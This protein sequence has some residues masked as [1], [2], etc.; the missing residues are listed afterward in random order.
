[1][2]IKTLSLSECLSY[3]PKR[4]RTAHKGDFG[5]VLVVGGDYGFGGAVRLA[6]E[7]ALRSGAGLV[8]IATVPE[9]AYSITGS[10]PEL[11][12][13]GIQTPSDL[14]VL[15][16]RATVIVVGMGLGK[17]TWGKLLL[18]ECLESNLPIVA[19]ADALNLLSEKN[20]TRENWILTPHP[21]EAARLLH[22]T[23]HE[24]QQ[25]RIQ[26]IQSIQQ[27]Y[28]GV[29]VLKGAETLVIDEENQIWQS[30]AGNPGM[31]TG[32]MGDVLSG[33]IGALVAQKL[34]LSQAAKLAV[35]VHATA[36]DKAAR[37]GGERGI[38]ASDLFNYIHELLNAY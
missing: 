1:M 36:G 21:G 27:Q 16:E 28:G 14:T 5:H 4:K 22:Q 30:N 17:S 3:L 9:H 31:A 34:S 33:I 35:I 25:N 6:G 23:S 11:M 32:G 8:S 29:V 19:D 26:A 18:N 10:C 12:A 37:A 15:L 20:K 38:K 24:V 7:G 2:N 13:H